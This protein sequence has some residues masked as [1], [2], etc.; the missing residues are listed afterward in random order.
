MGA[1]LERQRRLVREVHHRV[2]NN[3]Q[4]VASLL[5]I[6]SRGARQT[7]RR[8]PPTPRSAAGSTRSSIV[9]RNHY[10][11]MEENRGIALRPLVSELAA[12]LRATAPESARGLSD[13]ARP[14][15]RLHDPGRGRLGRFPDHRDRR[16]RHAPNAAR[17]RLRSSLRRTSELTA[18]LD[19]QQHGP[20]PGRRRRSPKKFSSNASSPAWPSSL[21]STLERK[22]GPLQRRICLY[23]PATKRR[24]DR[25]G[26]DKKSFR[27]A[28]T[29]C[30]RRGVLH[31]D[32][33]LLP[34]RSRYPIKWA[35]NRQPSPP[36]VALPGPHYFQG[37]LPISP[38]TQPLA[39][40]Q[41]PCGCGR[42]CVMRIATIANS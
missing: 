22:L 21:R 37:L 24:E 18:R 41:S 31:S 4:V 9:H 40:G 12:E 30:G 3:L 11:E 23:F 25:Y 38:L 10:A 34:P 14:R 2:K 42:Q 28:G 5:N 19:D 7:R 27:T 20:E 1:A 35:R 8:A 15:A 36:P 16:I 29:I 39:L 26:I 6:H 33:D 32:S 13:P 17:I